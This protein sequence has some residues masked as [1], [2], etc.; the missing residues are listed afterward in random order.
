MT[1]ILQGVAAHLARDV[2]ES[3]L[4]SRHLLDVAGAWLAGRE[5]SE[6][7]E[8]ARSLAGPASPFSLGVLD[9]IVREVAITRLTE[10]DDIH[11]AS[12]TTCGSVIIPAAILLAGKTRPDART[13]LR[14]IVHGYEAMMRL[15]QATNGPALLAKGIWPTYLVAPFGASVMAAI[16]LRLN[17]ER[18][19]HAMAIALQQTSGAPG[20]HPHGKTARW[21]LVGF[22][23]RSGITSAMMAAQD[24]AGD[25]T[26][27]DG[28][29]MERTHGIKFDPAPF[30]NLSPLF[31]ETSIKPWCSA[32]QTTAAIDAFQTL[33]KRGVKADDIA[34][35]QV[36]VPN[37][38]Q[39]M[40][41][42]KPPGRLG[43]IVNIGWQLG[44]CAYAPDLM[45][46]LDRACPAQ[47]EAV[48]A[49]ANKVEVV[50]DT[51]L[52][53]AYPKSWPARVLVQMKDGSQ[54][55]CARA[56]ALGDPE[57]P[58]TDPALQDKFEAVTGGQAR[59]LGTLLQKPLSDDSLNALLREFRQILT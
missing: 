57:N 9:E 17:E 30:Q 50:A 54:H 1:T 28:D 43:R 46:A 39:M 18:A 38:Y 59:G 32:K 40:I 36:A 15:G 44:L 13:F 29:W 11:R 23:A 35:I 20:G 25:L 56:N 6:G 7:Q 49:L 51:D 27:L 12:C 34:R 42:G 10:I 48:M 33:L 26:L 37:A 47:E 3:D 22:A 5:F 52:N 14:A 8:I 41:S 45:L 24:F 31:H 19:A 55:E 58:M 16:L 53:A 21:L 4:V 2:D